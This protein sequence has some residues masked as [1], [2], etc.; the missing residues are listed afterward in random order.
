[1]KIAYV[2]IQNFRKLKSCRI[3][4]SSK[5]TVFVGA[6]NSGKTSA[7]D[8]LALFL[9]K[10]RRKDISTT[11]FTLSNWCTI[12]VIGK[13]WLECKDHKSLDL[14]LKIWEE[15]LPSV[16]VW[17]DVK[18]NEIHYISLLIPTLSWE[19][20]LLGIRLRFEPNDLE[21]LYKEFRTKAKDAKETILKARE[22]GKGQKLN[23][24]PQSLREFLDLNLHSF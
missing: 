9:E 20:G 5:E 7:I 8:A 14:T 15:F 12:D 18:E 2:E 6:N 4:L 3:E 21:K 1:M 23:L 10:R 24:W 11:D 22:K 16:D 13:E 17:L 19:S